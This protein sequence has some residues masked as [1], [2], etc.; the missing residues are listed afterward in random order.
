MPES[1]HRTAIAELLAQGLSERV[2]ARQLGV[3]RKT[4]QK[5]KLLLRLEP[6]P[7]APPGPVKVEETGDTRRVEYVSDTPVETL[8]QAVAR[9]GV[10]LAVWRVKRWGAGGWT[11]ALKLTAPKSADVPLTRQNWR[12]WLELERLLSRPVHD[13]T[14]AFVRRVLACPVRHKPEPLPRLTDPHLC[15]LD[16]VDVH[17]GK[18]AWGAETGQDYDLRIASEVYR[19]AVR[20]LLARASAYPVDEFLIPLGSDFLHVD[21][22]GGTTTAGTPQDV[23]GRLAK[24]IEAAELAVLHAVEEAASRAKVVVRWIP[25]NHDRVLSYML[26]RIVAA[27]FAGHPRVTVDVSPR[28]RKYHRFHRTL[29]GLTHGNEEKPSLLPT[30]MAQ[31][32]PDDWAETSC[33]EWHVGHLH[34]SRELSTLPLDTHGG[35]PVR[36][37]RSL[38][39][40]DAWHYRKGFVGTTRAAEAWFYDRSGLVGSAVANVR[41][42]P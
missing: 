37:L 6:A 24:V 22:E 32:A 9:A 4:V 29:I 11:T 34:R 40:V 39:G 3:N 5:H 30:L 16:L 20:T 17:F 15:V 31:E 1:P 41:N 28:H 13:A 10:D 27:R 23:D 12:V 25:G 33:R 36:T 8:D 38:S 2:I 18:L 19:D 7:E 35:V 42:G 26:A 21:N 14:E